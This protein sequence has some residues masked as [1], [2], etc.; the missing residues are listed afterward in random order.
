MSN[1]RKAKI[2]SEEAF[3]E[4]VKPLIEQA[5]KDGYDNGYAAG[6]IDGGKAAE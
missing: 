1:T 6:K 2:M 5:Y 3:R 4:A